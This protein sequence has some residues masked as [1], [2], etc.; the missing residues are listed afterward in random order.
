MKLTQVKGNTWVLE[1]NALIPLYRIDETRCILLDTGLSAEREALEQAFAHYGLTPVGILCSHA[2]TDHCGNNAYLQKKYGIPVALTAPEAG[3]CGSLL[4]LKAYC[5]VLSPDIA[6]AEMAHLVHVPQ[7]ILPS[8]DC[9]VTFAG[10]AFEIIQTPGHSSGHIVTITP[11]RV[12]YMADAL[13]SDE[14]LGAKLP[15]AISIGQAWQSRERL[16]GLDCD[17]YI[18]AHRGVCTDLDPV[19]DRNN[20]LFQARAEEILALVD[21]PMTSSEIFGAVCAR[22]KLL[23]Q[24]SLRSLRFERNTRFFVEYL[25]DQHLLDMDPEEGV[26]RYRRSKIAQSGSNA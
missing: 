3:M 23:S 15:Y 17:A 7:V 25:V 18:M 6:E 1:A 26:V 24:R 20:D 4:N 19:I 14:M 13:L 16:R 10:V 12:G 11:D 21:R 9:T 2:H 8:R 22:F 5:L